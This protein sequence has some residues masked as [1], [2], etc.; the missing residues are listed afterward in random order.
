MQ[1]AGRERRRSARRRGGGAGGRAGREEAPHRSRCAAAS[2]SS[3]GGKPDESGGQRRPGS[4]PVR[5]VTRAHWLTGRRRRFTAA[6]PPPLASGR[7]T[8]PPGELGA[9]A[10]RP[11]GGRPREAGWGSASA[12]EG[13]PVGSRAGKRPGARTTGVVVVVVWRLLRSS[14]EGDPV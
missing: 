9:C 12:F 13:S 8:R 14:P 3:E 5:D 4:S 1:P 7:P 10:R 6:P 11:R 2:I